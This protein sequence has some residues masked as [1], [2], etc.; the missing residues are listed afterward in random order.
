MIRHMVLLRFR[1]EVSAGERA[2]LMAD[3][4]GLRARLPG[5][6]GFTTLRNVSPEAP[7]VH[8]FEDGFGVDF[9]DAAA[10]DAY[11]ADEGH[12]AI[13]ARLVAACDGGIEG[14]I[15]FDHAL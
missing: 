14:L 6:V 4:G 7:V 10:R 12:R 8:G 2:A 3:L 13:G 5:I 9:R 15:V 11:L 1:A